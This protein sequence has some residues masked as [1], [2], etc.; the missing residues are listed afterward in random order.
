MKGK[1]LLVILLA[2]VLAFTSFT[3]CG[4]FGK[5]DKDKDKD[6]DKNKEQAVEL[7]DKALGGNMLIDFTK[8]ADAS[9]VFES[10]GWTNGDVFNVVWAKENVKYENGKMLLSIVKEDKKAWLNDEEVTFPYSAGEARTQNYFGY[11]DYTVKM[12]PS[13]NPGTASTFFVCTGPYDTKY[14]LDANGNIVY[15][16]DGTIKSEPNRHDEIDIEFLG[17]DTTKVQFNFF[18][19][20]KGGNEYM[21]DL[22]FDA[23][24]E[25]HEY[26]FR[27]EKDSIT[28]FIDGKP[29]YKVTT[30]K[31][32]KEA[33]NV[34]IVDELPYT[35]GR[36][37]MSHWC[38]NERAYAWMGEYKG[39]TKDNG[40]EYQWIKTTDKGAPLNPEVTLPGGETVEVPEVDWS[41]ISAIK[42]TFESTEK[43][44]VSNS[45]TTSNVK[46]SAV[47]GSSYINVEMD[48]T[49][50][51]KEKN[52][53]HLTLK[54]NASK[55]VQ[56]RVNVVDAELLAKGAQNSSTNKKA[57][58]NG[59]EIFTDLEWGGSFFDIKAGETVEAVI[60]FTGNVEKLQLMIDS[61]RNDAETRSG[62]VTISDIKF[63]KVGEIIDE[64]TVGGYK[65]DP[66]TKVMKAKADVNVRNLPVIDGEKIGSL[67]KGEVVA[68]TGYCKETGWYRINYK[69]GKEGFVA[70]D[71]LVDAP[72]EQPAPSAP[73]SIYI[74]GKE[75]FFEGADYTLKSDKNNNLNVT[76]SNIVGATY[77]NIATGIA[78]LP[79]DYN[80]LTL[81]VKNNG[82]KSVK[83]RIDVQSPV[84][85]SENTKASNIYATQDGNEVYT[86]K[87]WGGSQFEI[88]AGKTSTLEIYF[89]AAKGTEAL[90]I[91]IDSADYEEDGKNVKH[92]GNITFSNVAFGKGTVP[93]KPSTPSQPSTP[94]TPAE[95]SKPEANATRVEADLTFDSNEIYTVTK[96]N[97]TWNVTYSAAKG[98]SYKTITSTIEKIDAGLNRYTVKVTNNGTKAVKVRIDIIGKKVMCVAP[99]NKTN[100]YACNLSATQ[101]GKAVATDLQW[102]GST[103]EIAAGK[104]STLE[105]VFDPAQNVERVEIFFDTHIYQDSAN[106]YAGNVTLSEMAF[107]GVLKGTDKSPI[108]SP[109]TGNEGTTPEQPENPDTPVQPTH[110]SSGDVTTT[111]NGVEV[112]FDG[113]TS[114]AYGVNADDEKNVLNVTYNSVVGDSYKNIWA[115]VSS[116]AA[117]KD[118][119]SVKIKNN[120]TKTVKV[121][122]DI[123]SSTPA[124]TNNIIA[125]NLSSKQDGVD[126]YTDLAWGGST[127]EIGAG[128][129]VTAEVLYD[130][131]RGP[132]NLK[133]YVDSHTYQDS[134]VYAG[135]VTFSEMAFI[136]GTPDSGEGQEPTPE[137]PEVPTHPISNDCTTTINGTVVEFKGNVTDGYGVN[138]D[139]DKNELNVTYNYIEGETY[140]NIWA[141]VSTLAAANDIFAVEITNHGTT[142]VKVRIDITKDTE[143][144]AMCNESATA[145]ENEA[146][147]DHEWGGGSQFTIPENSSVVIEIKYDNTQNPYA[148]KFFIDSYTYQDTNTYSGNITFANMRFKTSEPEDDGQGGTQ[149]PETPDKSVVVNGKELTFNS[150]VFAIEAND[151]EKTLNVSY[152][153]LAAESW[154]TVN[155]NFGAIEGNFNAFKVKVQNNGSKDVKLRVDISTADWATNGNLAGNEF[156]IVAND[157]TELVIPYDSTNNMAIVAMYIDYGKQEVSSGDIT[158]SE[159]EF[160]KVGYLKYNWASSEALKTGLTN[161]QLVDSFDMEY[162]KTAAGPEYVCAGLLF[163]EDITGKD[164][165]TVKV[166]NNSSTLAK[167]KIE[168]RMGES[169]IPV[170]AV[171]TNA[172]AIDATSATVSVEGNK[173]VVLKITYD[174][175]NKPDGLVFFP[176]LEGLAGDKVDL[177]FSDFIFTTEGTSKAA[178]F[179]NAGGNVSADFNVAKEVV[180]VTY[181]GK[182]AS[183]QTFG[184]WMNDLNGNNT[185]SVKIKNNGA[186]ETKVRVDVQDQ[187][188]AEENKNTICC[189]GAVALGGGKDVSTSA[190]SSYITLAPGEETIL[191]VTYK[192]TREGAYFGNIMFFLALEETDAEAVTD[193]TLSNFKFYTVAE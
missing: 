72:N 114:D 27:W 190:G 89:D 161:G 182:N 66:V 97:K 26:G 175:A 116:I 25:F 130:A 148:V 15:N 59:A 100:I 91:F 80:K 142:P 183:Y 49:A 77:K 4:L 71:Y 125:C 50:A 75:Y 132:T 191:V 101:D 106:T 10:D 165:F 96:E 171:A 121:R 19:N 30:D 144:G 105:V 46:Y 95:P 181:T 43:Y 23:S 39:N 115:D 11:G 92:S 186:K 32:V 126:T 176:A 42:P 131:D 152:E 174:A 41:K 28:W 37:L 147:T 110:P 145:N 76:Y 164:T 54:N 7:T 129:T 31:T 178:T 180:N 134:N 172:T 102:G 166:K 45:G 120:G 86:D 8:G 62:D 170:T 47:G 98:E 82:S 67:K 163:A 88:A 22:G 24:K 111:I 185:F 158:F 123:E 21:Y 14:V 151:A 40:C 177:T 136:G 58:M 13:A 55:D 104:T 133:I 109:S 122:I 167:F 2:L 79:S 65:I 141:N 138:A 56:V 52:V 107:V 73:N 20:G 108:V 5:K 94:D 1:R 135:N 78:G 188:N 68:V 84:K 117:N 154:Q 12:K 128:K 157:T 33:A 124:G 51:A 189:V 35:P 83:I 63:A 48:I 150:D 169:A 173:E 38:G 60:S 103:F 179:W 3:A 118:T 143:A 119:F 17:K 81:N 160:V 156:V 127:F 34:R 153:N 44:T 57:T 149:T 168:L 155:T 112:T 53:L 64:N 85:T 139:D 70:G 140:K 69:D 87:E 192:T 18:V 193:I 137:Q 36:L 184:A 93:S 159:M 146:F 187:I 74:S 99:D 9:V 16:A 113:N 6:K 61:S 29:V 90:I 162:D